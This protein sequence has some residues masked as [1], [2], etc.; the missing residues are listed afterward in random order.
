MIDQG[1]TKGCLC[2][3]SISDEAYWIV[4][5]G[6]AHLTGTSRPHHD[7]PELAHL[8]AYRS[9]PNNVLLSCVAQAFA[10][11]ATQI[12]TEA[13]EPEPDF[14][15]V[16]RV[17]LGL[18]AF[19]RGPKMTR[20]TGKAPKNLRLTGQTNRSETSISATLLCQIPP[21]PLHYSC[22]RFIL[23]TF[24]LNSTRSSYDKSLHEPTL[25]HNI[26]C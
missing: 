12:L 5:R 1:G 23:S 11:D 25:S 18:A 10:D 26:N 13:R 4:R 20:S 3:P 14:H 6:C 17:K 21:L 24:I 8:E 9:P 22:L 15:R 2:G 19:L 7:R 16:Q